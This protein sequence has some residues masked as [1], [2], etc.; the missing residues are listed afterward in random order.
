MENAATPVNTME[1]P[2]EAETGG[3]IPENERSLTTIVYVLQALSVLLGFT[4]IAGVI[5]NYVK[6]GDLASDVAKAHCSWQIRTF[7]WMFGWAI[8]GVIITTVTFGIGAIVF[9]I[10]GVW[11]IYRVVKGWIRLNDGKPV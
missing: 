7:W 9:P 10:I 1:L 4:A 3:A 5:V 11:Y 2:T 8:L 6:R